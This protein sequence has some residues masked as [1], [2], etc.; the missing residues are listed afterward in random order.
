MLLEIR[1]HFTKIQLGEDEK[2][3]QVLTKG[4]VGRTGTL[5][6]D[7]TADQLDEQDEPMG[8]QKS[9]QEL[10]LGKPSEW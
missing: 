7:G 4:V 6:N 2:L 8:K 1:E 10:Q 9:I 3:I 5:Q